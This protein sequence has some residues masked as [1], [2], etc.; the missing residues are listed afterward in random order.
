MQKKILLT[1]ATDG[2]G[3]ETA[4]ALVKMGHQV[5]LHGRNPEKLAQVAKELSAIAGASYVE[6]YIADLSLISNVD[7]LADEIAKKHAHLDV[8]INNAGVYKASEPITTEGLD[9]R[10]SVNTIAPYRLTTKLLPLLTASSRVINLS[11]AAQEPVNLEAVAGKIRI[12]D[13]FTVYAQSKLALTMWSRALAD[14]LGKDG[15]V[16]VA[17]N[18]GSLLASKMVKEGFGVA[19]KDI[20]I[21]SDILCRAALDSEFANATG[22]YFDNDIGAFSAPHPEALDLKKNSEVVACIEAVLAEYLG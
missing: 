10:F 21:G 22:Q 16:I 15:P 19:G 20:T 4:K 12:S 6:Q 1:G 18:P 7:P 2:I 17:V 8:I 11:S 9:V 13:D 3:A 5:L 14:K